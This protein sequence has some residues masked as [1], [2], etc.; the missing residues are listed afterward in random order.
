MRKLEKQTELQKMTQNFLEQKDIT[1]YAICSGL[2][3]YDVGDN[4]PVV[5]LKN[6][7][8]AK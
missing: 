5:L 1:G 7:M 8:P 3:E 6:L 4:Y 2:H